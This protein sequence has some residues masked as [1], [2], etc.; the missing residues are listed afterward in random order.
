M[1]TD[2]EIKDEVTTTRVLF[3][4]ESLFLVEHEIPDSKKIQILKD[5]RF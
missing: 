3:E 4:H 2:K 5:S 1:L